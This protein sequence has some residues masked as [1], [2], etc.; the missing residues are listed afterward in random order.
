MDC[1]IDDNSGDQLFKKLLKEEKIS[2]PNT[3]YELAEKWILWEK[4]KHK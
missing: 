1:S 4:H 3:K 2:M